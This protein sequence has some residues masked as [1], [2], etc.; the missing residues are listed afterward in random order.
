MSSTNPLIS[1]HQAAFGY[2]GQ[3]VIQDVTLTVNQGEY[4]GLTGPN[5]SGK[6]TLFKGLLGLLPPLEGILETAPSL[7]RRIGYVPQR[8]QLDPIYPLTARDVVRMGLVGTRPWYRWPQADDARIVATRLAQVGLEE[9]Q[10]AP[11]AELSSGQRQRVLMA[12]ALA[13]DPELLIL[14]EPTAGID[15]QAEENILHLL[16]RLHQGRT[17]TILMVSHRMASLRGHATRLWVVKDGRV[18][19]ETSEAARA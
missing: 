9:I 4:I 15:P 1:L 8:D 18:L 6:T 13:A 2:N 3:A 5:G 10:D 7:R 12:R 17:M 14:D 19:S 16:D 11:F